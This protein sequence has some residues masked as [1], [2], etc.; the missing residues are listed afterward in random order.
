MA[1]DTC[2][3]CGAGHNSEDPLVTEF[4]CGSM[5]S[6]GGEWSQSMMCERDAMIATLATVTAERDELRRRIDEAPVGFLMK[7]STGRLGTEFH[8]SGHAASAEAKKH[9]RSVVR[10]RL[11]RDDTDQQEDAK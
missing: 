8:W 9:G 6:V 4:F 3:W 11:I 10:V 1:S 7:Y 5:L 2:Q